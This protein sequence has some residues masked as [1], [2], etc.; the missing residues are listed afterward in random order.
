MGL[1]PSTDFK[2][3]LC[4]IYYICICD[5]FYGDPKL[6][7]RGKASIKRVTSSVNQL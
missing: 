1:V 5:K 6:N 3:W 7:F 4:G 2:I